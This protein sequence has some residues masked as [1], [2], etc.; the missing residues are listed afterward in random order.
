MINT[1]VGKVN[2]L[3]HFWP[4]GRNGLNKR[5]SACS[6]YNSNQDGLHVAAFC[7][8]V[9]NAPPLKGKRARRGADTAVKYPNQILYLVM[10]HIRQRPSDNM[11]Y[12]R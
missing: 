3:G 4:F 1:S 10:A 6:K 9:L 5:A 12:T 8:D 7:L 2:F 11:L